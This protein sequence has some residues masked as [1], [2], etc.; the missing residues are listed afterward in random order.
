MHDNI[1]R[2]LHT[3]SL[4]SGQDATTGDVES[5][6]GWCAR[7]DFA[8]GEYRPIEPDTAIGGPE[9]GKLAECAYLWAGTYILRIDSQ[10][11]RDAAFYHPWQR[12]TALS[13]WSTLC[14]AYDAWD[15]AEPETV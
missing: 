9:C 2:A 11:F 8:T 13:D 1:T 10:G 3:L 5:P 15:S 7:F 14:A 4:D 12:E 6:T